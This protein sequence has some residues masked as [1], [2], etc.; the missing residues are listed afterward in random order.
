MKILVT[1]ANGYIGKS[2]YNALKDKYEV[3]A[4]TR[5]DF[6]LID[7]EAMIKFFNGKYFDVVLHC[8]VVGGSRL[9]KESWNTMDCNLQIY[10]NL[11]QNR[12]SFEKLIQF[13]SG[14]E[15]SQVDKPYGF[16][17]RVISKSI[18][19]QSQFYNLRIYAV[20]DELELDRRFI[21]SNIKR[22]INKEDIQIYQNKY[23]SFF[24]MK[25][26]I[27]LVDL[28]IQSDDLPKQIDCAYEYD[29]TLKQI[30]DIINSLDEHKVNINIQIPGLAEGYV[31]F[32]KNLKLDYIGLEQG[33]KEVYNKL[34]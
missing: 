1:G 23:M 8:A 17:K 12:K 25:D 18:Q 20:F 19:E 10:Y 24:Y 31:A 29:L 30:A 5:Q 7:V 22:Y 15:F 14:A 34:K 3:I 33:I 2:L 21:K 28:Y 4:I 13:G 26:L 11:L 6:D 16:S 27:K 9:E 32:N